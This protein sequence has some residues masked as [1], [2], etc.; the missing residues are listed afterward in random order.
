MGGCGGRQ[1]DD[2]VSEGPPIAALR[3]APRMDVQ[4]TPPPLPL[5]VL[6]PLSDAALALAAAARTA[7]EAQLPML[8][9]PDYA[10]HLTLLSL[11]EV[12]PER[13]P[14]VHAAVARTLAEQPTIHLQDGRLAC[15]ST[16]ASAEA[17]TFITIAYRRRAL[18]LLHQRLREACAADIARPQPD[19]YRPHIT[20]GYL[21][22]PLT[23]AETEALAGR[24]A[25]GRWTLDHLELRSHTQRIGDPFFLRVPDA[26]AG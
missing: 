8:L 10:P 12:Q 24:P 26:P 16:P 21:P 23:A 13:V 6:A 14:A 7:V 19:V 18:S 2:G 1:E 15:L 17:R 25:G 11:G 3:Y 4:A 22:R 5:I 20:L 9:A